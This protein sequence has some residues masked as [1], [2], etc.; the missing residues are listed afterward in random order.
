MAGSGWA[1]AAICVTL[2]LW[3]PARA[4]GP[5]NDVAAVEFFEKNVRPVLA[6]HCFSCHGPK[7]Q[8]AGLRLD[9]RA[10]G[11]RAHVR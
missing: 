7:R 11:L 5:E 9:S 1:L 3:A 6:E 10:A 2:G 4:E 8:Q